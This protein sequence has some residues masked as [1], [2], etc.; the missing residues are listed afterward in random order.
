MF[1][2]SVELHSGSQYCTA[3]Y[4]NLC[5]NVK[6]PTLS[7]CSTP[8]PQSH[9]DVTEVCN[10]SPTDD[11]NSFMYEPSPMD[12]NVTPHASHSSFIQQSSP[13]LQSSYSQHP[14]TPYPPLTSYAPS[15]PLSIPNT[16]IPQLNVSQYRADQTASC[17]L[18]LAGRS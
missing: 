14:S 8:L 5:T 10:Y 1:T 9:E 11:Y 12:F 4:S 18:L 3:I 7:Y 15:P 16:L 6:Q 13:P 17:L 2:L